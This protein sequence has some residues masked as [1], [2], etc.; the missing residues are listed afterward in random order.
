MLFNVLVLVFI[1]YS[2]VRYESIVE[3]TMAALRGFIC[4]WLGRKMEIRVEETGL[5]LECKALG[6]QKW[7][8]IWPLDT[9]SICMRIGCKRAY[10]SHR[11]QLAGVY[12][13]HTRPL[14]RVSTDPRRT[15]KFGVVRGHTTPT[16]PRTTRFGIVQGGG[17]GQRWYAW[18]VVRLP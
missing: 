9:N 3:L 17:G 13:T 14:L 5:Q 8:R 16:I 4:F 10:A 11:G 6:I 15:T 18:V 1:Y 7:V 12:Q 2:Q